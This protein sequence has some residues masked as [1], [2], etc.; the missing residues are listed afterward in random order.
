MSLDN[1]TYSTQD[2]ANIAIT[3]PVDHQDGQQTEE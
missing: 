2:N 3:S 1:S